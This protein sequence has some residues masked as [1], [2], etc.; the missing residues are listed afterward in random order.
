LLLC[1]ACGSGD[2]RPDLPPNVL[3]IIVDTLRADR[4]GTYGYPHGS[5]PNVDALAAEGIVFERAVSAA[6]STAPSHASIFSS[7]FTRGHTIGAEKGKTRFVDTTALAELFQAAGYDTAAFVGNTML[8]RR[9]GFD[10]G[11]AVY[12]DELPE[13]EANRLIFER[14]ADATAARAFA[15]LED[16][17]EE[18]FFLWTHF[19]DPHGP[20]TPPAGFADEILIPAPP[21]E[22]PLPASERD[23]SGMR[24]IPAY[25]VLPGLV[26]PSAYQERY[27]QE[28]LF[29]DHWIG[30]LLKRAEA[31]SQ[32][33]GLVVLL[34]ADHGEA[35]GEGDR[36]FAHGY[37]TTPDQAH[38]P[39]ILRAPGLAPGRRRELAHHVDVFPTLLELAGL[40]VPA[41]A[42]GLA[43][44][45][46]LRRGE[47]LPDRIVYCDD[48]D[49]V[50]AYRGE[51][52][53]R[54]E[55]RRRKRGEEPRRDV[56]A[57][58]W[59]PDGSFAADPRAEID[60]RAPAFTYLETSVPVS[61][62]EA[63]SDALRRRLEALGYLLD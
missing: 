53:L 41:D 38:V 49:D 26:L 34:T 54:I 56:T 8:N 19:Q 58:R 57:Y 59:A 3:L 11:F 27:A 18:P 6:S 5:S 20:Y 61:P 15:W 13:T 40:E 37:A 47:A 28:I 52:F 42:V 31:R 10:R 46:Y 4:L 43:L 1:L 39:F 14:V 44:G 51:H 22:R 30:E 29:A 9:L 2:A 35:M 21:N 12:D 33:R 36:W 25:Q 16:P 23:P 50:S 55:T 45:P 63:P 60:W 62:A 17:R 7:R 32:D 24:S 48:G